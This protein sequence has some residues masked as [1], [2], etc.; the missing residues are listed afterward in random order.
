MP[1]SKLLREPSPDW[2]WPRPTGRA[3]AFLITGL[4]I[5]GYGLYNQDNAAVF[6][7]VFLFFLL[8]FS[9]LV[10]FFNFRRLDF[11]QEIP[12]SI[13]AGEKFPLKMRLCNQKRWINSY[14]LEWADALLGNGI[15][16]G[17]R[18]PALYGEEKP[19][20]RI[21]EIPPDH[22][23]RLSTSA[24]LER[25]GIYQ[26][27]AYRLSSGFPFGLF[28][29]EEQGILDIQIT[30]FPQPLFPVHLQT[31]LYRQTEG[32]QH[33]DSPFSFPGTGEFKGIREYSYGDPLKLVHWPLSAR[34]QQLVVKSFESARAEKL[35]LAFHSFSEGKNPG[36]QSGE[37][38]LQLL[39]GIFLQLWQS[40]QEF[41]FA[42]S[43]NNWDTMHV[44]NQPAVLDQSLTSLATAKIKPSKNLHELIKLLKGL[45]VEHR[46]IIISNVP[47]QYWQ[48]HLSA[49]P[50]VLCLDNRIKAAIY[51]VRI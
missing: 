48:K 51:P 42:A 2:K 20:L 41:D 47:V 15:F 49:Y 13:F 50:Q 5:A 19:S 43:F 12:E 39:T 24:K 44:G 3:I 7:A 34:H 9:N 27:F 36:W 32:R 17:K 4:V 46:V 22:E 1:V 25:R 31:Y 11:S 16:K 37:R 21:T 38:S 8:I 40:G 14:C 30:A 35:L 26:Q 33:S 29:L 23:G 45:P 18:S 6:L 10:A 28:Q